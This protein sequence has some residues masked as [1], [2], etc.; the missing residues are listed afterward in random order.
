M[1]E[2]PSLEEGMVTRVLGVI[3]VILLVLGATFRVN[4]HFNIAVLF[5]GSC[6]AIILVVVIRSTRRRY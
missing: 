4:G 3:F 5:F 1:R 2:Q 6:A